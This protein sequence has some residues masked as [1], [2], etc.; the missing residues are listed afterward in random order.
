MINVKNYLLPRKSSDL[1]FL[2]Q[3]QFFLRKYGEILCQLIQLFPQARWRNSM[4]KDRGELL[5]KSRVCSR[6]YLDRQKMRI[7]R[8]LTT[9]S[10]IS[11]R[12]ALSMAIQHDLALSAMD[13]STA[14]LR[15]LRFSEVS[16]RA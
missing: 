2:G 7:D 14:F 8:H 10:R 3:T 4:P 5:V 1:P 12:M 16:A 15:G 6:G 11:H 13:I 9:A